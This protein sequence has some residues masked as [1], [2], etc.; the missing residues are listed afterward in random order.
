MKVSSGI[1]RLGSTAVSGSS[2]KTPGHAGPLCQH[3]LGS[4]S[5]ESIIIGL[6]A[7]DAC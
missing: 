2:P 5:Y 4:A 3:V 1:L 7:F 6:H